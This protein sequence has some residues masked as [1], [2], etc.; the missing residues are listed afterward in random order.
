[1]KKEGHSC[2][3]VWWRRFIVDNRESTA[4]GRDTERVQRCSLGQK[5]GQEARRVKG[6]QKGA[7]NQ[8]GRVI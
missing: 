3:W 4:R 1:M 8:N 7:G 5:T 2:S 6:R